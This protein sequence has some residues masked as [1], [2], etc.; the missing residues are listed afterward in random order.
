MFI[1]HSD[2]ST[3]N[4]SAHLFNRL[5]YEI[6]NDKYLT[7]ELVLHLQKI[8]QTLYRV[9]HARRDFSLPVQYSCGLGYAGILRGLG[10]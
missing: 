2:M 1:Q 4:S 10:W 6:S 7:S 8:G 5:K 3:H 9:I